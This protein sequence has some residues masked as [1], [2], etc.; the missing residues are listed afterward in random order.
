[1]LSRF[2]PS[3]LKKMF[4]FPRHVAIETINPTGFSLEWM[5]SIVVH[6]FV[7]NSLRN[8]SEYQNT[9]REPSCVCVYQPTHACAACS[10]FNLWTHLATNP[11]GCKWIPQDITRNQMC[12][13][14]LREWTCG[15]WIFNNLFKFIMNTLKIIPFLFV[16]R[17]CCSPPVSILSHCLIG[18]TAAPHSLSVCLFVCVREFKA[19]WMEMVFLMTQDTHTQ[20]HTTTHTDTPEELTSVIQLNVV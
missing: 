4:R 16:R 18:T 6:G 10:R 2:C 1:M 20:T 7:C 12:I 19:G 13:R 9:H 8:F 11:T 17:F 14:A 5:N 15:R 3:P